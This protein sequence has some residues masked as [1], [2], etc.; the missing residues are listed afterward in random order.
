MD[1]YIKDRTLYTPTGTVKQDDFGIAVK[2]FEAAIA[3]DSERND[4]VKVAPSM[5]NGNRQAINKL[6]IDGKGTL[7]QSY[8]PYGVKTL[9]FQPKEA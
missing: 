6:E 1:F 3:A 8:T 9:F 4:W 5:D 7:Y 2:L